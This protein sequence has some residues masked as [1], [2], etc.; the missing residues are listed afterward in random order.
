[1]SD[2]FIPLSTPWLDGKEKEYVLECLD[3]GWVAAGSFIGRFEEA[4]AGY[5]GAPDAVATSSGTAAIHVALSMLGIG[6]GDEVICPS[7]TFVATTNA[8]VHTGARP[9][10]VDSNSETWGMDPVSLSLALEKGCRVQAD[11]S[12]IDLESGLRVGAVMV[13]HL[14]GHPVD[15]TPILEIAERFRLPVIEDA[16]ESLGSVYRGIPTGIL[17]NIGC[18]SFNGNKTITSGGGGIIVSK[19]SR[20]VSKARYLINQAKDPG[21]EFHHSE[22][23]FNYRLSNLH[24]AVGLAQFERLEEFLTARRSHAQ[25]YSAAF[26]ENPGIT[27]SIEPKGSRSNYWLSTVLLN[28][29]K[30]ALPPAEVVTKMKEAGIEVRR[31]FVPNHLL[32]PYQQDRVFGELPNTL[33]LYERGLNL[34]SSAWLEEHQLDRI[35]HTLAELGNRSST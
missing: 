2:S 24:A 21:D 31:P 32:P 10:Y 23:G 29:D 19:D 22:V 6:F 14:Y 11:G 16:T 33:S 35:A 8:V 15:M 7:L 17:G 9:A 27:F 1:M 20:L 5:L 13:V 12:V 30:F 3:T 25:R 4:V 18:F 26:A 28:H 34:P